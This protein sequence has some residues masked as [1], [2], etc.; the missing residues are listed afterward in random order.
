MKSALLRDAIG[1]VTSVVGLIALIGYQSFGLLFF[2]AIGA[3][4]AAFL[5]TAGS[6]VLMAQARAL[7]TGQALPKKTLTRLR[8]TVLTTPG[9]E[10]VN[11]LTAVYA[12]TSAVLV[13]ADLD[14]AEELDTVQIEILLDLLE[15]RVRR[16]PEQWF[17]MHRRWKTR[18]PAEGGPAPAA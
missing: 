7:I 10:A 4:L 15:E 2:D 1:T 5:M 13:D 9:V 8:R 12:G 16:D 6:L 17:W 18:P 3:L 11:D 14:L